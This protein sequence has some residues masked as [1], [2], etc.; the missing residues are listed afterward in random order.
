[1]SWFI[2][3]WQVFY[4]EHRK[5][6]I[7]VCYEDIQMPGWM[8]M[9]IG[10]SVCEVSFIQIHLTMFVSDPCVRTAFWLRSCCSYICRLS[11]VCAVCSHSSKTTLVFHVWLV[12][13]LSRAVAGVQDARMENF[14]ESLKARIRSALDPSLPQ[15]V[16]EE[17]SEDIMSSLVRTIVHL[18]AVFN[19]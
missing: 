6:V 13:M 18:D 3:A 17:T 1:M 10:T 9:L 2:C 8:S 11:T 7:P 16:G 19:D 4:C 5:R 15:T 14:E 12:W